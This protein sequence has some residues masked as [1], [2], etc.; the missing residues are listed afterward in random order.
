MLVIAQQHPVGVGGERG[1]A[2]ARQA[3]KD[4]AVRRVVL[5]ATRIIFR[6]KLTAITVSDRQPWRAGSALKLGQ[7]MTVNSGTKLV[8]SSQA[9]RRSRWRMNRPCQASSFTMRTFSR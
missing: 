1:F 7:L 2:G 4:G 6:A 3:K 8:S 5:S 9:G